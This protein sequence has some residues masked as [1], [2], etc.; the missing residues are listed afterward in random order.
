MTFIPNLNK[1]CSHI[2]EE[3]GTHDFSLWLLA[4]TVFTHAPARDP[5]MTVTHYERSH[6]QDVDLCIVAEVSELFNTLGRG[7]SDVSPLSG[8]SGLPI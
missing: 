7:I 4:L 1:I 3:E 8:I 6:Q 2:A 5:Q